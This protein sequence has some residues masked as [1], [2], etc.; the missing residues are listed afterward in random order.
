[1]TTGTSCC[2]KPSFRIL[3]SQLRLTRTSL[4]SRLASRLYILE[5]Q[6]SNLG[7]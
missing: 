3:Y 7:P 1:M 5:I 2:T 4:Y 6:D